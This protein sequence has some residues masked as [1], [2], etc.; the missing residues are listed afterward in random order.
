MKENI[1]SKFVVVILPNETSAYEGVRAFKSLHAENSL[2]V[3]S[4][5]VVAKDNDGKILVRET[6][7]I[8]APN[9][10]LGALLGGLIGVFGGP[11]GII[12]GVAGG[13]LIGSMGDLF[14]LGLS[15]G[16]VE[17][18]STELAP[19]KTAVIAEI[20]EAWQTPLDTRMEELGGVV[21]RNWRSDFEDE[22]IALEITAARDSY[23]HLKE[24]YA[25]AADDTKTKLKAKVSEA[26]TQFENMETRAKTR[27]KALDQDFKEKVA[28]L[29]KQMGDAEASAKEKIIKQTSALKADYKTRSTKL[30]QA[31]DLTKDALAA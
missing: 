14:N 30:K 3:Y 20:E 11:V 19:G 10:A 12:A 25:H 15:A 8:G 7:E 23:E 5:A 21:L 29:E 2:T 18:V 31:W 6:D 24:E 4:M 16:F 17:K 27:V 26:K 28:V 1:M 22:Q 13:A 9:F